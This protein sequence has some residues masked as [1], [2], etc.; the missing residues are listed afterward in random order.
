MKLEPPFI[1]KNVTAGEPVTAQAWN[2]LVNG[3]AAL[4]AYIEAS[5]ASAVKVQLGNTGLDLGSVRVAAV[6]DDG[7][8]FDAVDPVPPGTLFTFP[9]LKP[10]AYQLRAEAPGYEPATLAVVVPVDGSLGTQNLTLAKQG[11]FMPYLFG[12]S[13]Q[14]ALNALSA[15]KIAVDQVLDVTGTSVPVA[16]PG[17][18]YTESLVLM[19]F[20]PPGI[21]VIPGQ[22][23]QLVISAALQAESSV[24]MPSL[25]G[26]TLA[27]ATKALEVL[28]LKVGKVQTRVSVRPQ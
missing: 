28:G 23:A 19:Q 8:A 22:A 17:A 2:D 27:E 25:T 11:E 6:R 9:G 5:E 24:E 21:A 16:K 12:Q 10:G 1:K 18:A 4:Y 3:I 15:L 20:P 14:E 26:L 13:L 7:I